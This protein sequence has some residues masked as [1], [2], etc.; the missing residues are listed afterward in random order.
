MLC[1]IPFSCETPQPDTSCT[2][3]GGSPKS[4][5]CKAQPGCYTQ[6]QVA[7]HMP[8]PSYSPSHPAPRQTARSVREHRGLQRLMSNPTCDLPAVLQVDAR[9][10]GHVGHRR[11]A[12]VCQG[13]A[14]LHKSKAKISEH[15]ITSMPSSPSSDARCCSH[16]QMHPEAYHTRSRTV[17]P[18]APERLACQVGRRVQAPG[19]RASGCK[20]L[21]CSGAAARLQVE[22]GHL[23]QAGEREQAHV[24]EGDVA[25]A[26]QAQRPA[27]AC[28]AGEAM[29]YARL[30]VL[31]SQGHASSA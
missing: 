6:S 12:H 14:A 31:A 19:C 10:A 21:R 22:G 8:E 17:S 28:R 5:A 25:P 29:Q 23:A 13:G 18:A 26:V 1:H 3:L 24:D 30:L 16:S 2:W 27:Q 7:S 9:Q 11:Q 15:L 4:H 20:S